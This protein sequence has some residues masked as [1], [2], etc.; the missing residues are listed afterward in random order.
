[1]KK[2]FLTHICAILFMSQ[3]SN[4]QLKISSNGNMLFGAS[5]ATIGTSKFQFIGGTGVLFTASSTA[6]ASSPL[7]LGKNTWSSATSPDYTWYGNTNT[8][9]FHAITNNISFATAGVERLRLSDFEIESTV[10]ATFRANFGAITSAP[11]IRATNSYSTALTPDYTWYNNDQVGLFHPASNV[12][13][14]S[15]AGQ[16]ALRVQADKSVS[17]GTTATNGSKL[18]VFTNNNGGGV[19]MSTPIFSESSHTVDYGLNYVAKVNRNLTKCYV[20]MDAANNQNFWVNGDGTIVS[21][22]LV[23]SSDERLKKD[24]KDVKSCQN[25]YSIVPKAYKYKDSRVSVNQE[26]IGFLAQDIQK[27]YPNLVHTDENGMLGI[28]YIGLIPIMVEALKEQNL[29]IQE[30]ESSITSCCDSKE[31]VKTQQMKRLSA[32]GN[33]DAT[34]LISAISQNQP[35]P[36][37]ISTNINYQVAASSNKAD[38]YVFDMNGTLI[39]TYPNLERGSNSITIEG[40]SLVAGM[41]IYSLVV[42]GEEIDSK[43]MILTK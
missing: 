24:I 23:V 32:I 31:E 39:K 34:V 3:I 28:N 15:I 42:D 7:I 22:G 14:I 35:N 10:N 11:R 43:R 2:S 19:N 29:R 26:Q 8:G 5:S 18:Y 1:M 25:L 17:I 16:E 27:L 9:I 40:G 12:L 38:L 6:S 21:K 13:G 20:V 41:Y 36:F 33:L 4:A 30:L 37:T